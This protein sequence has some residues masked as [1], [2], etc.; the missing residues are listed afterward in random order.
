MLSQKKRAKKQNSTF[1]ARLES[2][3]RKAK[4]KK[5]QARD[6]AKALREK[7]KNK[8]KGKLGRRDMPPTR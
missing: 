8:G 2:Q 1:E 3:E 6:E 4:E 7:K 5:K